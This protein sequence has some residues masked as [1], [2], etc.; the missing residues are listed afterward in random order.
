MRGVMRYA[1][2]GRE[3]CYDGPAMASSST[4]ALVLVVALGSGCTALEPPPPPPQEVLLRVSADPGRPVK[5]ADLLFNGQRVAVTDDEGLGKLSLRGKDGD[6]FDVVVKCPQGYTSPDRPVQVTLR[7]LA[8]PT[9]RPEYSATCPP[10]TR[11]VVV[12]VRAENGPN[13]PVMYLGREVARTDTSGAAHVLLRL[14]PEDEFDLVLGTGEKG[15]ELLR[16]QNPQKAFFVKQKDDVFTFDQKFEREK[17]KVV[18]RPG[19][20]LPKKF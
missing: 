20:P 11:Q 5:G 14:K 19:R 8:D 9:K 1:G 18:A 2:L 15:G 10:T 7:R 4:A 12:A 13:L 3:A 17:I 16:P 6:M